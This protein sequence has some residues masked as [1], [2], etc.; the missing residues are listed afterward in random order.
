MQATFKPAPQPIVA[1]FV[2]EPKPKSIGE[3][4]VEFLEL[5]FERGLL[6]L[7]QSA[8]SLGQYDFTSKELI[9][10]K[11]LSIIFGSSRNPQEQQYR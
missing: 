9:F 7:K 8:Q 4:I 5:D 10:N 3:T 2:P 6:L 11:L 1:P